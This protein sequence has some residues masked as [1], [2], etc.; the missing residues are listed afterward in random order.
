M[1][2]REKYL[3]HGD[4]DV[5]GITSTALLVRALRLMGADVSWYVPHRQQEGYDIGKRGVTAARAGGGF[6][7][8]RGLRQFVRG[9]HRGCAGTRDR[10]DRHRPSRS[11]QEHG[12]PPT[13]LSIQRNRAASILSKA[14]RESEWH[15]SS[16][17]D[18]FGDAA[19]M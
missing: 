9:G 1:D 5:D 14:L 4:Y 12:P 16:P 7:Y 18:W 15:I 6:D 19:T 8:H 10:C 11:R 2:R 3:V 17:R 13:S